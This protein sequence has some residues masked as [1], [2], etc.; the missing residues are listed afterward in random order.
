MDKKET[1]LEIEQCYKMVL[2][3]IFLAEQS[4]MQNIQAYYTLRDGLLALIESIDKNGF[5][6]ESLYENWDKKIMW[7]VSR[8]FE[9]D[10]LLDRIL[11]IDKEISSK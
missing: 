5:V 9:G 11:L 4:S 2:E 10:S 3:M 8:V 6:E 7:W 1:M